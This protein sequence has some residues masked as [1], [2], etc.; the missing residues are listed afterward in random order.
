[1]SD[2]K[3]IAKIG[4][5]AWVSIFLFTASLICV[6]VSIAVYVVMQVF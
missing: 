1:M 2:Y 5:V 3:D 4:V 6:F